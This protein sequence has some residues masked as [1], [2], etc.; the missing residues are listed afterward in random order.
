MIVKLFF[1]EVKVF[2]QGF[3]LEYMFICSVFCCRK[4][5]ICFDFNY[6]MVEN[7]C[8]YFGIVFFRYVL[9]LMIKIIVVVIEV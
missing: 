4:F 7:F 3:W 9:I 8:D 5:S 6:F 2:I 1:V